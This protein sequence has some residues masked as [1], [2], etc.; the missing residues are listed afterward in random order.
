MKI[1]QFSSTFPPYYGGTGNTCYYNSLELARL[2]EEVTVYAPETGKY[3]YPK[4]F[5]VKELKKNLRI[6]NAFL[7][8]EILRIKGFEL[9]HLH[10]PYHFGDYLVYRNSKKTNTP[11]VMTYQM[12]VKGE[13]LK[14]N[15]FQ[16][17]D[18]VVLKKVLENAKRVFV[19]SF[20]YARNSSLKNYLEREPEKFAE[21]PNG[22]DTRVFNENSAEKWLRERLGLNGKVVGFVGV[23]D[24]AHYFK[25][26]EYLLQAF[27]KVEEDAK[28]LIVGDGDLRKHFEERAES[29]GV[30]QKCVF[31]GAVEH[32]KLAKYYNLMDFLV[33]PSIDQTEAFGIVQ[34][35]AMACSKPVVSSNLYGVRTLVEEG[36]NGFFAEPKDVKTL[37]ERIELLLRDEKKAKEMGRKALKKAQ[38]Y[39]WKEIA[40][41]IRKEYREVIR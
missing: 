27:S 21:I 34:L 28:L 3:S 22:V 14:K 40:K 12:D 31:A 19:T 2:G 8:T 5:K 9:M 24:K 33:F 38:N 10:A 16:F 30:F 23:L 7:S 15:F 41:K 37:K 32:L 18:S 25:G 11:F 17:Y 1:C 26:L 6:G 36:I 29:L 35:E 13:G 4:E 20:D 39:E